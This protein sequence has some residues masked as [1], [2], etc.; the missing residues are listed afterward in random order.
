MLRT[1]NAFLVYTCY[2]CTAQ[3]QYWY[4]T[5]T[6]TCRHNNLVRS[7]AEHIQTYLCTRFR[8]VGSPFDLDRQ[9]LI[10]QESERESQRANE[11]ES[12]VCLSVCINWMLDHTIN[13]WRCRKRAARCGRLRISLLLL[14]Q[15]LLLAIP[16]YS[17]FGS[18]LRP[19][20]TITC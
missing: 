11:T 1:I 4:C 2:H 19:W 3:L 10:L 15:L 16:S 7:S 18:V 6:S 8:L 17:N 13:T 12:W 14:L 5:S 9:M 20:F